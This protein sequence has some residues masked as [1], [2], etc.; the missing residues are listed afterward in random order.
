MILFRVDGNEII[1]LGH[2]MRCL[3]IADALQSQGHECVFVTADDKCKGIINQKGFDSIILDSDYNNLEQEL[4]VFSK[5]ITEYVPCLLMI[6]SYFVTQPY[7]E[8]LRKQ[9][10]IAYIDD[11]LSFPYSVDILINYNIFSDIDDYR[12]L[13]KNSSYVPKMILGTEYVPLRK[14]FQDCPKRKRVR[15]IENVF[16]STGGAD[17]EHIAIKLINYISDNVDLFN[18]FT[19]NFVVGAVN[20]DLPIINDLAKKI[21]NI[22]IHCNVENMKELMLS[23]DVAVS[24]AGSTLYEL[25]ACG[26]PT[27]TYV[28]ADNQIPAAK[29]FSEKGFM[30]Y[31]GDIRNSRNAVEKIFDS[32]F[33]IIDDTN[34]LNMICEIVQKFINGNGA[35]KIAFRLMEEF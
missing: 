24:A 13:Y 19:F 32:F 8:T 29:A 18:N 4:D 6:D 12:R 23:N 26:V 17:T 25:C 33:K 15:K 9:V 27:I 35:E 14:E 28:L 5:K 16:V 34:K 2:I 3:S 22:N 31:A 7:F 10:E 30:L 21:D 11:V 1:G 20:S